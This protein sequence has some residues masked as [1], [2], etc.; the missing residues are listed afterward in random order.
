MSTRTGRDVTTY[1]LPLM[2]RHRIRYVQVA[3][4]GP[5]E[6]DGITVLDDSRQPQ[7]VFLQGAYNSPMS[8]GGMEPYPSSAVSIAVP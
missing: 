1:V 3:R 5:F 2:R 4:S 6:S 7:R 8:Y